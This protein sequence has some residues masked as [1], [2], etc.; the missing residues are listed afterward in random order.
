MSETA[1]D[2]HRGPYQTTFVGVEISRESTPQEWEGYGEVLRRVDE[3][4]QWAIGDWLIDG[5]RHYGDRLYERAAGILG[6]TEGAL[7][8]FKS[9]SDTLELSRRR[10]SVPWGHHT[11]VASL[12]RITEDGDGKLCLSDETDYKKIEEFLSAAEKERLSA[13]DLRD[14]VRKY[15]EEQ[16]EHIRLAN[17]PEKCSVIY[18]DPPWKD[19][20]GDGL[21]ERE[22][23]ILG[24]DE[25]TLRKYNSL[26]DQ[27]ELFRHRNNVPWGRK[28][29]AAA[30]TVAISR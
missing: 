14:R 11:E 30:C 1:I 23:G 21:Y 7:R 27:L 20:S 3:A 22:A 2:L 24:Q 19:T 9:I 10:D 18:A 6:Y 5:K 28:R 13:R 17:A 16:Q 8:N 25:S 15:K 4:K 26:S 29:K 12:K